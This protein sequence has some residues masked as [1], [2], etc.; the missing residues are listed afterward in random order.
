MDENV[1]GADLELEARQRLHIWQM[2][3]DW[4]TVIMA[5]DKIKGDRAALTQTKENG[6]SKG[7]PGDN[8]I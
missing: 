7:K 1:S 6:S 5:M 8:K 4:V 2:S 3:L